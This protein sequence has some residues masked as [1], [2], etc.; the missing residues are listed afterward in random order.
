M[1]KFLF[2]CLGN[3]CRSPM[4]EGAVRAEASARGMNIFT[5]SAG[6]GGWHAGQAPDARSVA[7]CARHGVDISGLRARQIVEDDYAEFDLILGMDGT[8]MMHL[9][10]F[11]PD[12]TTHKLHLFGTFAR[13]G[14]MEDPYYS[15]PAAFEMCWEQA[16]KGAAALLDAV[17][18]GQLAR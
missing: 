18:S 11:A 5:D 15:D 2:V 7:V 10:Q 8:N 13:Q 9:Q 3:I 6:T 12:G 16:K 4:A 17:Q 1:Q 14:G